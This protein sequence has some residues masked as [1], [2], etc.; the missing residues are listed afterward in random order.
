MLLEL[1]IVMKKWIL[2]SIVL[3]MAPEISMA[4]RC[5]NL[6]GKWSE[7]SRPESGF[8]PG[9]KKITRGKLHE[10]PKKRQAVKDNRPF[11]SERRARDLVE[12]AKKRHKPGQYGPRLIT[13]Q[14]TETPDIDKP[15]WVTLPDGKKAAFLGLSGQQYLLVESID[16]L[17]RGGIVQPRKIKMLNER[18]FPY[19]E[20]YDPVT[21]EK[22]PYALDSSTWDASAVQ[23]YDEIGRP[24]L[25][26]LA[27]AMAN[28]GNGKPLLIQQKNAAQTR[29]RVV[30]H[31]VTWV[32]ESPGQW[33]LIASQPR[34]PFFTKVMRDGRWS[35]F[36][37]DGTPQMIHS[38]GGGVVKLANGESY[39]D[40]D[41]NFHWAGDGVFEV[42]KVI[43]AKEKEWAY[44]PYSSGMYMAKLDPTLNKVIE[45]PHVVLDAYKED[46][47]VFAEAERPGIGPLVEGGHIEPRV[48]L[49]DGTTREIRSVEDLKDIRRRGLKEYMVMVGS[50]G[51]Y[52][53]DY[54]SFQAN[55]PAGTTDF[56]MVVNENGELK[57]ITEDFNVITYATGRPVIVYGESGQAYIMWHGD[58]RL[59]RTGKL[60]DLSR[61]IWMAPVQIKVVDGVETYE[62][63][64]N[65]G[66][67]EELRTYKPRPE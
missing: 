67:L 15:V 2:P 50:Q 29:R 54:G 47:S 61:Q 28:G 5:Q 60:A 52:N 40:K 27:G 25:K 8:V 38:Y 33:T 9:I 35:E 3:L 58:E 19:G 22:I 11:I 31:Q 6:Y 36:D 44:T 14:F 57:N 43:G 64:D 12:M 51:P 1:L 24:V 18:G 39:G 16:Q 23:A 26:L 30:F 34:S 46:G 48:I 7:P 20:D 42:R 32:E 10:A 37:A 63:L 4:L 41:G 13:D 65:T 21:K 66:L 59:D 49:E 55:A 17:A 45:S 56:K 53:K 62:I